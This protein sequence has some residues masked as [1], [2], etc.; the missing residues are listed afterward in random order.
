MDGMHNVNKHVLET[1]HVRNGMQRGKISTA[2]SRH[3]RY[4]KR[5]SPKLALLTLLEAFC[6]MFRIQLRMLLKL[7]SSLTSYTSRMPMAPR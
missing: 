5:M 2:V 1:A 3:S 6:S 7:L 4:K